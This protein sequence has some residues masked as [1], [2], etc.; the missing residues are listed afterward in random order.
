MM[1]FVPDAYGILMFDEIDLK[2]S[3]R[4]WKHSN[5]QPEEA[6]DARA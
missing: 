3:N 5:L 4:R 6:A 1:V 2:T